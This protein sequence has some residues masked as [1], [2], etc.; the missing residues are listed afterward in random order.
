MW[1]AK[2]ARWI[3]CETIPTEVKLARP[4]LIRIKVNL[5]NALSDSN[6]F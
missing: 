6:P 3:A 1:T 2:Y 5:S 4:I